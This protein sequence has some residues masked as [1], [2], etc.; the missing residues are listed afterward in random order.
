MFC[1]RSQCQLTFL[2]AF[3]PHHEATNSSLVPTWISNSPSLP[4]LSSSSSSSS[5]T[6]ARVIHFRCRSCIPVHALTS[7]LSIRLAAVSFDEEWWAHL[8]IFLLTRWSVNYGL[9]H[10]RARSRL[11]RLTGNIIL[12]RLRCYGLTLSFTALVVDTT[13]LF[14][15]YRCLPKLSACSP[16]ALFSSPSSSTTVTILFHSRSGRFLPVSWSSLF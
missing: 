16:T 1:P 15:H 13:V 12:S 14:R 10:V 2:S 4:L 6:T 8:I 11:A 3:Q 7:I 9:L 5:S